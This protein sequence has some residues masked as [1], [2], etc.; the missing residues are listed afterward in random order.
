MFEK[1]KE[2]FKAKKWYIVITVVVVALAIGITA[3]SSI[4]DNST[5]QYGL[6]N[7][8]IGDSNNIFNSEV[9]T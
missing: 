4:G 6:T 1:I 5:V 9:N 3:C 8:N 2:F 7:R